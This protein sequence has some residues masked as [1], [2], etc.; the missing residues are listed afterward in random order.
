MR[1]TYIAPPLCCNNLGWWPHRRRWFHIAARRNCELQPF[2]RPAFQS[3][4][5]RQPEHC[6][7]ELE[8]ESSAQRC[9]S[10]R[11]ETDTGKSIRVIQRKFSWLKKYFDDK[12]IILWI[13][14]NLRSNCFFFLKKFNVIFQVFDS[15]D[16][17]GWWW[18]HL[19][20]RT[21]QWCLRPRRQSRLLALEKVEK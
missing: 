1:N 6:L 17:Y 16:V 18:L 21:R 4:R 11:G 5:R 15:S 14:W 10:E 3:V 20:S 2:V 12:R 7:P 19:P 9:S 13:N 8:I